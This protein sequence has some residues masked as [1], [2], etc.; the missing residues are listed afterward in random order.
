MM[1]DAF[2]Q[3][4]IIEDISFMLFF[5]MLGLW[6]TNKKYSLRKNLYLLFRIYPG[7]ENMIPPPRPLI[8][9]TYAKTFWGKNQGSP[10]QW[11]DPPREFR[12]FQNENFDFY[13]NFQRS[14]VNII[15]TKRIWIFRYEPI[16]TRGF[17][18][19]DPE[20]NFDIFRLK[21]FD[22][23]K[24]F[25]NCGDSGAQPTEIFGDSQKIYLC[26]KK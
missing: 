5:L 17:G 8:F 13:N 7:C 24:P 18:G 20:K 16:K 1:T 12:H 21:N 19:G 15:P 4:L 25:E 10:G 2:G 23:A 14:H 3:K 11:A 26:E 22:F 9:L 6:K